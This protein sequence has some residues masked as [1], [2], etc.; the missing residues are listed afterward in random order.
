M[1]LSRSDQRRA[2]Y[3]L[4]SADPDTWFDPDAG[5]PLDAESTAQWI[6]QLPDI[7]RQIV[8]ARIW[9]DLTFEQVAEVVDRPTATVFRLFREAIDTMRQNLRTNEEK[10][11]VVERKRGMNR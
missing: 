4:A 11:T 1:N 9:G 5:S 3:E 10:S 8:T 6:E 7:Q 2:R